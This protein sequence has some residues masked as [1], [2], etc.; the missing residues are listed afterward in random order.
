M[1]ESR[2]SFSIVFAGGGTGGHL[3]PALVMAGEI[4]KRRPDARVVFLSTGKPVEQFVLGDAGYEILPTAA[5]KLPRWTEMPGFAVKFPVAVWKA[6]RQLR[7]IKP[8]V[9]FG[10]GGY[11]SVPAGVAAHVMGIP[12]A[13]MSIDSHCGK[14]NR[15]LGRRAAA[16]FLQFEDGAK[17]FPGRECIVSGCPVRPELFAAS[18]EDGAAF[19]ELDP[20]RK[21]VLVL[22]GSQGAAP[23]NEAMLAAAPSLPDGAQILHIAG[24]GKTG[25]LA[26]AY[27]AAG[28]K[29]VVLEYCERMEFAYSAA[30]VVLSRAGAS[31]VAELR[32]LGKRSLLVPFPEAADDHQTRNAEWLAAQGSAEL[33]PQAALTAESL[34][35]SLAAAFNA[36]GERQTP[37]DPATRPE[38]VIATRLLHFAKQ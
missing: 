4:R 28:A 18:R 35:N 31:T 6:T 17:D 32:A 3:Y 38:A 21:T 9:V 14:A 26:E 33:L 29:A 16:V 2:P 15:I 27:R 36:A 10:L 19:F 23:L 12:L 13:L 24:P 22:G 20:A 11:G 5:P 34:A 1:N 37:P 8:D 25:D 30:D 7:R